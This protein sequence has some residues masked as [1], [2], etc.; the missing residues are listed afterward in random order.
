MIYFCVHI[1]IVIRSD[2]L[3]T[4]P[5]TNFYN[6]YALLALARVN[7]SQL[8]RQKLV[9]KSQ[10]VIMSKTKYRLKQLKVYAV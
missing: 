8:A 4:P 2:P 10:S 9:T 5:P 1:G 6:C 7:F 3:T